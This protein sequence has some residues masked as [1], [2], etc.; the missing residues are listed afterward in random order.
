MYHLLIMSGFISG[1]S[2]RNFLF[3]YL[4]AQ[5]L[6]TGLSLLLNLLLQESHPRLRLL[7]TMNVY[8]GHGA[9]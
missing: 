2:S 3:I 8:G 9:S 5:C 4:N 7:Y 1:V 6:K